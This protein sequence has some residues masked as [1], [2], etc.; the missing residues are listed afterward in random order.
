MP[1][2]TLVCPEC[3]SHVEWEQPELVPGGGRLYEA[4]CLCGYRVVLVHVAVLATRDR[5]DDLP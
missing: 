3:K 5:R 1:F 4:R 2:P